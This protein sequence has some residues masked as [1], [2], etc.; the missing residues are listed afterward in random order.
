M[1]MCACRAPEQFKQALVKVVCALGSLYQDQIGPLFIWIFDRLNTMNP[2][3]QQYPDKSK[4]LKLNLLQILREVNET[5]RICILL[6]LFPAL[7]F[8]KPYHFDSFLTLPGGY[9]NTNHPI[10]TMNSWTTLY[11]IS[12]S[13]LILWNPLSTSLKFSRFS[14]SW[15]RVTR[16]PSA[17][18][19]RYQKNHILTATSIHQCFY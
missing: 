13:L 11:T 3:H 2:Q 7:L 16:R 8:T 4:E 19:S 5:W 18:D 6:S 14:N 12:S 1:R 17:R 10:A 15:L 9:P